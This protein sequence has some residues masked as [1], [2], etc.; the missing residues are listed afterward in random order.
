MSFQE[1]QNLQ[2]SSGKITQVVQLASAYIVKVFHVQAV[3]NSL[4][5]KFC[6]YK[7]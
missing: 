6:N 5:S 7:I 4:N 3:E 2:N 1:Y